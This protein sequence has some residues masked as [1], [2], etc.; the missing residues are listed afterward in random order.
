MKKVLA[1]AAIITAV[2]TL[3]WFLKF[4]AEKKEVA[5]P[6][7]TPFIITSKLPGKCRVTAISTTDEPDQNPP[8]ACEVQLLSGD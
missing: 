1:V 2:A 3:C 5:L 4:K 6:I 7:D 8:I